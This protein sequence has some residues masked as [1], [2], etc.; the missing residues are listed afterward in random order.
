MEVKGVLVASTQT[1]RRTYASV[2]AQTEEVSFFFFFFKSV[3]A[4]GLDHS[5]TH[6]AIGAPL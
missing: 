2:L 4:Y 5:E 1:E 3:L 6:A